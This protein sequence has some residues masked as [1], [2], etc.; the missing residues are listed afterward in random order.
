MQ[1]F[2]VK[3]PGI[4]SIDVIAV[5]GTTLIIRT[6]WDNFISDVHKLTFE[7]EETALQMALL[8]FDACKG[9]LDREIQDEYG[10]SPF[11]GLPKPPFPFKN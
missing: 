4:G 11:Y 2:I 6:S 7:N 10:D 3:E 8:V 1:K 9:W 5:D